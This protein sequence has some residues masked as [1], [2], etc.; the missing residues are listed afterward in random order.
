MLQTLAEMKDWEE[1]DRFARSKKSPIGY[2]VTST[3]YRAFAA[4][5]SYRI[6]ASA[7]RRGVHKTR[8]HARSQAL[9][10]QVRHW[11]TCTA[12]CPDWRDTRG[13]RRCVRQ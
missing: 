2:E 10:S 6:F 8:Q 4:F 3:L 9:H 5:M 13:H 12:L 11:G 1:L 7:L